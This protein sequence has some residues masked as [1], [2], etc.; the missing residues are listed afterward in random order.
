MAEGDVIGRGR[1]AEIVDAGPGLVLRRQLKP[2]AGGHEAEVMRWVVRHGYPAPR[3]VEQ[4][5]DGMLMQ[6]VDGPTMLERLGASDVRRNMRTL[7]ELHAQLHALPVPP[8]LATPYGDG[9][10]LLHGDLHPGNVIL[11]EDGPVVIDWTNACAGP[12]GTDLATA[13]LLI[14]CAG[15]PEARTRRTLE[16][17]GRRLALA[18]LLSAA[19]PLGELDLAQRQLAAVLTQR[20]HDPNMSPEELAR[21]AKVVRRAGP[22]GGR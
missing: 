14:A 5:E 20:H 4:T 16:R 12:A 17:V 1:D 7:A 18:A 15:L 2:R 3:V 21:M 11:S 9:S 10:A 22:P 19:K 13:W 8:G 6:R